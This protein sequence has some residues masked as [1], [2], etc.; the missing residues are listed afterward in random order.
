[1]KTVSTSRWAFQAPVVVAFCVLPG[2]LSARALDLDAVLAKMDQS[3][4]SFHAAQADFTWTYVN[5]VVNDTIEQT[6]K[7]AIERSG[8]EIKMF[9]EIDPPEAEQVLFSGGKIQIYRQKLGTIDVYDASN[10]HDEVESFLG[11]GFGSSG[12]EIRRSFEANFAG[13]EKV[14]DVN[15]AKLELTPKAENI[16]NHFPQIVLWIDLER[17]I[18]VQQK[19]IEKNQSYRLAKYSNIRPKI[20][21]RAFRLK[22][23][24][25]VTTTTH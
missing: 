17:G 6:G 2:I 16:R 8:G 15:T 13:E 19:L 9:A 24:G 10:H 12:A 25:K 18:A 20:S 21:D 23:S 3:A 14:G 7:I 5:S 4:A 1:M 11:L 22:T